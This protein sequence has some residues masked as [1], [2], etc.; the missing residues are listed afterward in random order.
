MKVQ[1]H[2]DKET[3]LK[4]VYYKCNLKRRSTGKLCNSK[5][6]VGEKIEDCVLDSMVEMAKNKK[7][8]LDRIQRAKKENK[9]LKKEKI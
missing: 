2:R 9:K 3:G 6:L 5:N 4:K 8:F 7:A 1:S